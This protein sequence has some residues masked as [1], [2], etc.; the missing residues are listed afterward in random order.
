MDQRK[1]A[2]AVEKDQNSIDPSISFLKSNSLTKPK[3]GK[4]SGFWQDNTKNTNRQSIG[5]WKGG[6]LS[7]SK[8]KFNKM[9][10]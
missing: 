2:A 8:S 9:L 10:K 1:E 3:S 5:A 6:Q 4:K 7:I